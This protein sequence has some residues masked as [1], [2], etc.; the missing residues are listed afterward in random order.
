MNN[1]NVRLLIQPN[2]NKN[3]DKG[4]LENQTL[5]VRF[6]SEEQRAEIK[7]NPIGL[8]E[9]NYK[10]VNKENKLNIDIEKGNAYYEVV[11][12]YYIPFEKV[13]TSNDKIEVKVDGNFELNVN[14]ILKL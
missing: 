11:E 3:N 7:D 14:D 10:N 5:K 4:K 6:N 13:D 2:P 9:F 12:E 1:Q 8:Y